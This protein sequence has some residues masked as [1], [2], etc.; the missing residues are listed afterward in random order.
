MTYPG[1]PNVRCSLCASL[2]RQY[3]LPMPEWID[4]SKLNADC[5]HRTLIPKAGEI[6]PIG[7]MRR[8]LTAA[9][10]PSWGDF[11]AG[12]DRHGIAKPKL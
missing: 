5:R 1:D 11:A 6:R 4:Q 10:G 9:L 7:V 8:G 2:I 3:T 12:A